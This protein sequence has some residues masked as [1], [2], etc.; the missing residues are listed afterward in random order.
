MPHWHPTRTSS[1]P[2]GCFAGGLCGGTA[3][4]KGWRLG[5][6]SWGCRD[7]QSPWCCVRDAG[8]AAGCSVAVGSWLARYRQR[9]ARVS[10]S[11]DA[12]SLPGTL[13]ALSPLPCSP[14]DGGSGASPVPAA[15]A[16]APGRVDATRAAL[17]ALAPP[18]DSPSGARLR[19]GCGVAG[20][21]ALCGGFMM[22]MCVCWSPV[23]T[24]DPG[25]QGDPGRGENSPL[26]K[27]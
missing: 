7:M 1:S 22:C 3:S 24:G 25:P 14:P 15:V 5:S 8:V 27:H 12:L 17:F 10:A 19:G 13:P 20:P 9:V 23:P 11:L 2:P 21:G 16:M 18:R 26:S 4:V 6:W